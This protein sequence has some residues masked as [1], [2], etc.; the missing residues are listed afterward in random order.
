[1]NFTLTNQLE[2]R[3]TL[4]QQQI[5]SLHVL[6][7]NNYDLKCFL[8]EQE[9]QNPLVSVEYDQPER[10]E[11]YQQDES[12]A[13]TQVSVEYREE[14]G[15]RSY[16]RKSTEPSDYYDIPDQQEESTA[17]FLRSQLNHFTSTPREEQL[18]NYLVELVDDNGYLRIGVE[19]L[20][21]L[22]GSDRREMEAAVAAIQQLTPTGVGAYDLADCLRLQ[23]EKLYPDNQVLRNLIAFHLEDVAA[24]RYQK[25][26]SA[27]N[28]SLNQV[29]KCTALLCT[30]NPKPLNGLVAAGSSF[31]VPDIIYRCDSNSWTISLND[32]WAG[33]VSLHREYQNMGAHHLDD[34]FRQ[35]YQEKKR[36][37]LFLSSCVEKRR[38]TILKLAHFLLVYQRPFFEGSGSM[39][40][41]TLKQ[42]A[43]A[44]GLHDSTVSRA[45]RDKYVQTP[46]GTF[47]MK[48]FFVAAVPFHSETGEGAEAMSTAEVKRHIQQLIRQEDKHK[49]HSDSSLVTEL[50]RQGIHISR[51]TVAKYRAE[52]G[53]PTAGC[54]KDV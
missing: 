21:Y 44:V 30:L 42:A 38:Q 32:N 54:R 11:R 41:L 4:S 9:L 17:D 40:A 49:P 6:A 20:A 15:Q 25:I 16:A 12:G 50:E 14:Q 1:M 26:A 5:Y 47:P 33:S 36:Q 28:I 19:E 2:Q 51:R 48:A 45:I 22:T 23:A 18:L 10:L 43:K 7:M 3:Q 39:K 35:Y 27:Q 13:L 53:I 8:Q 52:L 37:A 29:K 34:S 24:H 31:V 46:L